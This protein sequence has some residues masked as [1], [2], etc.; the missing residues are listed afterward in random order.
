MTLHIELKLYANEAVVLRNYLIGRLKNVVAVK[1]MAADD[2]FI[3]SEW[4]NGYFGAKSV[5]IERKTRPQ[6]VKMP[7]SVARTLWRNM[8]HEA[9]VPELQLI[10]SSI[11]SYLVK[12]DLRPL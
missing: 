1:G 10:L 12:N 4:L 6:N 7:V 5:G 3:L 8:Q 9:L 11:D 2:D